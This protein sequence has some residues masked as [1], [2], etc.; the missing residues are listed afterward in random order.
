MPQSLGEA[1]SAFSPVVI[2]GQSLLEGDRQPWAMSAYGQ[3]LLGLSCIQWFLT[4]CLLA[5]L[6]LSNL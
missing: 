6:S 2:W 4:S 5:A 1:G 3:T